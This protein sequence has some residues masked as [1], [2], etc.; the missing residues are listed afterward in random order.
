HGGWIRLCP[1]RLR[2]A[3][4]GLPAPPRGGHMSGQQSITPELRMWIL[5]QHGDGHSSQTILDAMIHS[6]WHREV[7]LAALT[8]VL[9]DAGACPVI[10]T[11]S[12]QMAALT[13]PDIQPGA[14]GPIWAH[15]RFVQVVVSLRHPR[16]LVFAN[17]ASA[18]ECT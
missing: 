11:L 10:P 14:D 1:R 12:A 17:V 8:E 16:L 2:T 13:V 3:A 9:D 7:A 15:D 18:E 5:E 4:P 6:G